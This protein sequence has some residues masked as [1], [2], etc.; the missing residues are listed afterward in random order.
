MKK[1]KLAGIN[2]VF[3]GF[4]SGNNEI[5]DILNKKQDVAQIKRAND[6]VRKADINIGG[7]FIFGLP[8]DTE[9]TMQETFDLAVEL[10]CEY[11]NFFIPMAYPGT[12]L[13]ILAKKNK[14]ELP[15][16]WEQYGFF[17]PDALPLANKNLTAE[18][19][20]K[21]RDEA[22]K[23]YFSGQRYQSMIR[24]RFGQHIVDFLN[25]KVLSK[26]LVRTRKTL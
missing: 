17:A 24:S 6:I 8:S 15:E 21:F 18:Q 11:A 20:L 1:M 19:I 9:E 25:D 14:T 12:E 3:M 16:K 13:H 2:W 22:F 23:T 7:N 10:N 26:N 5:L 4:E